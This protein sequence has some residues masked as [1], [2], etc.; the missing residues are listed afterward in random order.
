[1]QNIKVSIIVKSLLIIAILFIGVYSF[2]YIDFF[3]TLKSA[4]LFEQPTDAPVQNIDF[5]QMQEKKKEM[6]AKINSGEI[7]KEDIVMPEGIEAPSLV[8]GLKNVLGFIGIL[9]FV[10]LIIY[11]L[12]NFINKHNRK[13]KTLQKS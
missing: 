12:D 11:N 4:I 7:N 10:V 1:M 9:A 3:S 13:R 2:I 8:A 6:E 5:E